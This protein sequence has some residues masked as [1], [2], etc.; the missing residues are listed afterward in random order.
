MFLNFQAWFS[1]EVSKKSFVFELQSLI[2]EGSLAEKLRFWASKLHF[3]ISNPLNLKLDDLAFNWISKRMTFKPIEPQSNWI[4]NLNLKSCESHITWIS[5]H[6]LNL[7]SLEPQSSWISNQLKLKLTDHRNTW[8]SNRWNFRAVESQIAW[9]W[10]PL[11]LKPN[12][13]QNNWIWNQLMFEPIE[14]HTCFL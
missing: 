6:H 13:T 14:F 7:K 11:N 8:T 4:W 5:S 9:I 3:W 2:C 1:K 12:D 10:G